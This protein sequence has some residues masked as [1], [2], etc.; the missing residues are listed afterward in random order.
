MLLPHMLSGLE[1]MEEEAV[2]EL[3][4][5]SYMEWAELAMKQYETDG[6]MTE[7][8]LEVAARKGDWLNKWHGKD[9]QGRT[10][11]AKQARKRGRLST[12]GNFLA[13]S[14]APSEAG[15]WVAEPED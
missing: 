3:M 11:E 6:D 8:M 5:L 4:K 13:K 7:S 2:E 12:L 9:G 14:E 15:E 10:E 1:A